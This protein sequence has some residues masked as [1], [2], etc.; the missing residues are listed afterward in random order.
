MLTVEVIHYNVPLRRNA[1][2]GDGSAGHQ[3]GQ[4]STS[5]HFETLQAQLH[6]EVRHEAYGF[7][8]GVC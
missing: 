8:S 6:E 4:L 7:R 3:F 1:L 5:N 2:P